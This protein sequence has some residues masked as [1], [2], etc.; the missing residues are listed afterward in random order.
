ML[1]AETYLGNIEADDSLNDRVESEDVLTIMVDETERRRSRFRTTTDDGTDIGIVVDQELQSG[2]VLETDGQLVVVS[3]DSITAMVLDFGGVDSDVETLTRA[4]AL[5]HAVGNRHWNL[6]VEGECV[7]LPVVESRDRMETEI[8][9]HL[10]NN[11]TVNYEAVEL[12]LFDE[13]TADHSH[14]DK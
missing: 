7:Y 4:V 2:D 5:G 3:L 9:S 14:G 13:A 1:V 10:P 6:S 11:A 12:T 8:R